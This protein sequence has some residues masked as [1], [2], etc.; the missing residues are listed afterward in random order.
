M[1]GAH[2]TRHQITRRSMRAFAVG[3]L[4]AGI[5]GLTALG[6][7][8]ATASTSAAEGT[9]LLRQGR[10]SDAMDRFESVLTAYPADAG[11]RKGEAAAANALA[12]QLSREPHPERALDVLGRAVVYVPDDPDLLVNFGVDATLLLQFPL[13]TK[14]L[15]A[16]LA[17]RP[18][19]A[20][21]IYAIARLETEEQHLQDAERDF[22]H[23]LAIRPEDASAYFGL[24]H[25]YA[26]QQRSQDARQAFARSIALK[27]IQTESYYQLGQMDLNEQQDAAA[28][29]EFGKVLERKPDHAGALT[30]MGQ[31]AL[32]AKRYADA[33][34]YL[35][36][37]ERSD[38]GYAPPHYY[39]GL[40]LARLG[41]TE[42]AQGELR[43]GD[44][45]PHATV[46]E[47]AAS[48]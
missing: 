12:L 43:S 36:K 35:A 6:Q 45:R 10:F 20:K 28:A 8:A 1:T 24:G 41:R 25:V 14:T 21:T 34:Q 19:D 47:G 17:L 18:D 15:A 4:L 38:P 46:P 23:Y 33:E 30:G 48:P 9:A 3:L 16:A 31:L 40:A 27:P 13:A 22:K 42:E 7:S 37:A 2:R 11:A 32:R 29:V 44:S 26:M 5:G 39:R